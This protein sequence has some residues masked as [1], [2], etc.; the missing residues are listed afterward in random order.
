M[1]AEAVNP[2]QLKRAI[3]RPAPVSAVA[4]P[5]VKLSANAQMGLAMWLL[6]WLGYN[7][8]LGRVMNPNFPTS[9]MDFIH[10]IRAFFPVLAGW[11]SC[12]LI[13]SRG[14]RLFSWLIGPMGLI[15]F[16]AVTG[17]ISSATLSMHPVEAL[18]YGI[19][20]F[21]IVLVL[22]A[23]VL[24]ED[25][26]ADLLRLL[27]MTWG[28]GMVLTLGL[29][30]AIPFLGSQV[31]I[32]TEASPVH[33]RAYGGSGQ[34]MG[35]ASSRNTGFARYAA[36]SALAALPGVM[37]KGNRTARLVW[38]ALLVASLYALVIANGRTE[39]AAFL[40][41]LVVILAEQ[42]AKRF[43]YFLAGTGV[44]ILLGLRGFYHALYLYLTRGGRIDFTLTGRTSIWAAGWDLLNTSPWVGYG[45]QADRFY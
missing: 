42:K 34:L 21:C 16:Y 17:L 37:R 14:Q 41:S 20:Y 22:L 43:I 11:F 45:F 26:L 8:D 3:G 19:N 2:L 35:M 33:M 40:V 24:V 38:A 31:I 36:I 30:G 9:M 32:P 39:T 18:Y 1:G 4:K 7:T 12:L 23:I 5:K 29:L 27:R 15:V 10:G 28:V 13:F 6:L 25:P 44:A